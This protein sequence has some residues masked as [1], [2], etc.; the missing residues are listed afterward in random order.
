MSTADI[1][2]LGA[3]KLGAA[4]VDRWV[5]ADRTVRV[6]NRTPARAEA[7]AAPQVSAV[8]DLAEAVRDVPVVVSIV[9][10]GDALRDVLIAQGG[11]AAMSAGSTLVDLSTID[12][13]SSAAVAEEAAARGI[14]FV[15]GGVSGTAAVVRAGAAGLLL[16]GPTEALEAAT[17]ILADISENRVVVGEAE[18]ARIAKLATNMLLAG[19]M[20]V[21]AEAVVMAE[22]SGVS[23]E[24]LLGAL[25]STVLS[26]RFLTY[27]GGAL[28]NRDYAATFRTA[29]MRKDV[30]LA[31]GQ[32]TEAGV[33]MPVSAR[34]A[35]QLGVAC[36]QGWAD[37]DFLSAVRL[38]QA[39][40]G[41]A[42]DGI[43]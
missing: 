35:E 41:Q 23:R 17:P 14:A 15:R 26:S 32:A 18:E 39:G 31:L 19:T 7:L 11:L 2:L 22:A 9:T 24:V 13:A 25:D 5:A 28:R 38:V 40:A 21:L 10:D 16:S 30:E 4:A 6:W 36:E 37:D 1:T 12:V 8:A 3:G 20:Q 42:I 29:D 33:P 34:I 27:K 43:D